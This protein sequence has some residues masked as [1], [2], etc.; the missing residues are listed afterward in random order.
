MQ[1]RT[2]LKLLGMA[3]LT[4]AT[5]RLL[6]AP[7]APARLLFVFL[8]GGYDAANLL[9]PVESAFYYEARPSIAIARPS[10]DPRAAIALTADWGLHPALRDSIHPLYAQG[11]AAFIPFTGTDDL[12]R[13]HF[14]TQD[15]MELGLGMEGRQNY[16]SGFLNRLAGVLNGATPISFTDQL[17]LAFQG[18]AQVSNIALRN[19]GK[20]AFDAR[21]SAIIAAMYRNGPLAGVVR[22]GFSTRDEVAREMT[23]EMADEM[24]AASRNAVS[25]RGFE[26]EARRLA[27]LMREKYKLGFIDI[28]GWDTHVGQGGASGYLA[29]RFE[30]LGRGLAA[31]AEEMKGEWRNTVVVV[32]SEFGRT[33]REN[34]NH[35]TDHGHGTVMWLLGGGIRGGIIGEQV[36]L[37]S[38]SLFQ[39]RDYPVLNEYRAVLA[40]LFERMYGLRPDQVQQVFPGVRPQRLMLV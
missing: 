31:F 15:R 35:G 20:P 38:A 34:G 23:H 14:E 11:Q 40:G 4:G 32:L 1:R 18:P 16:R 22:D 8:R 19:L 28:G 7:V 2:L 17:P 37:T 3:S 13:S 30:E 5:G 25:A 24:K 36:R 10:N 29:G 21:Q 9:V 6:A 26:A 33:F 39:N 27:P 12:S